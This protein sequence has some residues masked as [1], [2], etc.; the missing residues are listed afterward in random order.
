MSENIRKIAMV[1]PV[2]GEWHIEC[3]LYGALPTLL[4]SGNLPLLSKKHP[5]IIYIYTSPSDLSRLKGSPLIEEVGRYGEVEFNTS[6]Y[7]NNPGKGAIL[8]HEA[9]LEV[10][11]N[12]RK[13]G[14]VVWSMLPDVMFSDN[15]FASVSEALEAG[16]K[17]IIWV[18]SRVVNETFVPEARQRYLDGHVMAIPT[19]EM[20]DLHLR[21]L[22][23]VMAAYS[24]DS[25]Y[26]PTHSE[27]M[28]WPV[29]GEGLLVRVLASVNNII[30]PAHFELN[31]Y[32]TIIGDIV[33]DDI[34][35]IADSD[36]LFGVSLSPLGKDFQWSDY[37][38]R[39]NPSEV[40]RWWL[41]FDSSANDYVVS[42]HI[43]L[44]TSE[45]TEALW[46][47]REHASDLFISRAMAAREGR[48]VFKA[49]QKM[50]LEKFSTLIALAIGGGSLPRA[51][52]HPGKAIIFAPTDNALVNLF[53][54]FEVRA[55][56]E[57]FN[58]DKLLIKFLRSHV[59]FDEY[60]A[61]PLGRRLQ[62]DVEP[63]LTTAAGENLELE[64]NS[65][66]LTINGIPVDAEPQMAGA[67]AVY[68][69][70]GV[71]GS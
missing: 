46:R 27:L 50:E 68:K 41:Q 45:P 25:T 71:L 2:W 47:T 35:F 48:R 7:G 20:V 22:H 62:Y 40:A 12:A 36:Q 14:W 23:P 30:D 15:S 29:K 3:F 42:H 18:Y 26:F 65:G 16:K 34:H 64:L 28:V 32:H 4:A 5:I 13:Q 61:R 10:S 37:P 39:A 17:S 19:R 52:P 44:H 63:N 38:L 21:H 43:R 66:S 51:F 60:P 58:P 55:K 59:V 56:D 8:H 57:N 1:I 33:T 31:E 11:R 54:Y 9:W 49:V 69:L 67:H 24:R 70:D 53:N 6:L